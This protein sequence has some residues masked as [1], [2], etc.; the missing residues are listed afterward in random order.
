MD[1][2]DFG[3]LECIVRSAQKNEGQ[4]VYGGENMRIEGRLV[5]N[6]KNGPWGEALD[7]AV[8]V[9]RTRIDPFEIT[10]LGAWRRRPTRQH[11][12]SSKRLNGDRKPISQDTTIPLT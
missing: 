8:V 2:P 1:H 6:S 3:K 9:P 7:W 10:V 5:T 4:C 11:P 12:A